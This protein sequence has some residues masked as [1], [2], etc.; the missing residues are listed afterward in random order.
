MKPPLTTVGRGHVTLSCGGVPQTL[1]LG[2][3]LRMVPLEHFSDWYPWRERASF[4]SG[5]YRGEYVLAASKPE[6]SVREV[7]AAIK[8]VGETHGADL[9]HRTRVNLEV[10]RQVWVLAGM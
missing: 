6:L 10:C 7:P 9:S 1:A 8:Y 5:R 4:P 2:A 3:A